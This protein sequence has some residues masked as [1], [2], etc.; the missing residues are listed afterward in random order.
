MKLLLLILINSKNNN[1]INPFE[2]LLDK[3]VTPWKSMIKLL[4]QFY[5][6][7]ICKSKI[8]NSSNK[9]YL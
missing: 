5:L 7:L 3:H 6:F 1:G 4:K 8:L 2:Y 9:I